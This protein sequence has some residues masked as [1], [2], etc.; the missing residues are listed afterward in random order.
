MCGVVPLR[1]LLAA[2]LATMA[3]VQRLL[4]S[5]RPAEAVAQALNL[6]HEAE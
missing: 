5:S 3:N 4:N 1:S 2:G 6:A